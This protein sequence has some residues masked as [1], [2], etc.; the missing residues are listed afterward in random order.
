MTLA[1]AYALTAT[2]GAVN[3]TSNNFNITAA[4]PNNLV[5]LQQPTNTISGA[6]FS[7][8]IIVRIRDAYNNLVA[9]ATNPVSITVS[10]GS[11]LAGTTIGV[12]AVNGVVTFTNVSVSGAGTGRV[13]TA[14]AL[15][16]TLATSNSFDV[17][18][19]GPAAQLLWVAQPISPQYTIPVWNPAPSIRATD[20]YSNTVTTYSSAITIERVSGTGTLISSAADASSGLAAF[21]SIQYNTAE[22]IT[23]RGISGALTPTA[24]ITLTILNSA[25]SGAWTET[26]FTTGTFANCATTTGGADVVLESVLIPVIFNY[27][28]G[29]MTPVTYDYTGAQQQCVVPVGAT[30]MTVDVLGAQGGN[31]GNTSPG[32]AG[33]WV[34]T[35]FSVTPGQTFYIYVGG[36]GATQVAGGGG[37]A[38]GWNGGGAGGAGDSGGWNGGAGGGGASDIRSGGTALTNRLVV[39]GGGGGND[40]NFTGG[41]G[42]Q[43]GSAGAGDY[44]GLGGTQSAGG[45]GGAG[46]WTGTAGVLGAGGIGGTYTGGYGGG[47]GGGGGYGGGGAGG[48]GGGGGG[49][50]CTST[51]TSTTYTDNY[52]TGNNGQIRIYFAPRAWVVPAGVTSIQVDC[53]GAR[54]G[55]G[56]AA[57]GNGARVQTTLSVIPGQALYIYV[58]GAGGNR[59]VG[60]PGAGGWN[61]GGTG[62]T[63]GSSRGGGGGGGVSDIRSG[64]TALTNRVVVA[65]GGGAGG[66]RGGWNGGA[67]GYPNGSNGGAGYPGLGGTQSAGGAGDG[68]GTDGG[69]GYGGGGGGGSSYGGGGGGAGYYGGGGGG[70]GSSYGGGGGGGSSWTSGPSP[71]W[72]TGFQA[73]NGQII[74]TYPQYFT[75]GVYTSTAIAPPSGAINQWNVLTFTSTAPGSTTFTVDVLNEAGDTVL[76][77]N[78]VSGG[79][80]TAIDALTNP[81][82]RLR[83]NLATTDTAVTPTLSDWS[84]SYTYVP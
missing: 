28:A 38:G 9:N 30:E 35:T 37:G 7:P 22:D 42:G 49:G 13:L 10:A 65:G 78:V 50:S 2:T 80:L 58:G 39:A 52:W 5:F 47:G 33:A 55:T 27:V 18:A 26:V 41:A 14:T 24:N 21:P 51:G 76:L 68:G 81:R 64:G 20:V 82:I 45:A 3:M 61:G 15:G 67:G 79:S 6:A 54:G 40:W 72:T 56:G 53:R 74:I 71:T 1:G 60:A 75:P 29:G 32:G 19:F 12:S 66:G 17:S 46:T 62:G 69:L 63:G 23:V 59:S 11:T 34:R 77:T 16:L 31:T 36:V 83:A 48:S 43:N 4:T 8:V 44:P 25:I 57:G 84:V 73:G 70:R